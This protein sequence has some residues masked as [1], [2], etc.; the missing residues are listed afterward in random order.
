M[1]VF[2]TMIYYAERREETQIPTIPIGFW[3]AIITMTTVG[4]GDIAP[5]TPFGYVVGTFCA[6]SGVLMV[7]LTIPVISN[8]FTLF[9]THMRTRCAKEDDEDLDNLIH[10]DKDSKVYENARRTSNGS[11]VISDRECGRNEKGSDLST[12]CAVPYTNSKCGHNG[13]IRYGQMLYSSEIAHKTSTSLID[14]GHTHEDAD[15]FIANEGAVKAYS[16]DGVIY[17]GITL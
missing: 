9:Y 14:V 11:Y 3:W 1:L 10:V 4:Y 6:I 17:S 16:D 7:A 2:A 5:S 8:N 12:L 15:Y 13:D